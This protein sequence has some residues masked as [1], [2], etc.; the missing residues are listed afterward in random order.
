MAPPLIG[1]TCAWNEDEER[2]YLGRHYVRA[3]ETAGGLPVA[4]P[5]LAREGGVEAL[6]E[7]LNGLLLAGGGD[8]DPLHFG[9]EPL[10]VT[11]EIAPERDRFELALAR[12]A[13]RL[14]LPV[15]GI[16]R[17]LQVLNVAAGGTL[18][19][20]LAQAV[21][22][23]LKHRQQAPGWYAT[24]GLAVAPGSR[25]A[26]ILGPGYRRVN[27]FH[28]QAVARVAPGFRAAAWAPDGVVEAVEA[29][30]PGFALG[31]QFHAEEMAERD[32]GCRAL[33]AAL[34]EAARLFPQGRSDG[35]RGA[36]RKE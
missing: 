16:C 2:F 10:P 15:L 32:P 4:L 24:H 29:T 9:E 33:F 14:G 23:P 34:V 11:G 35:T 6:L 5:A 31:V 19:Q 17:G 3:V 12:G 7:V 36:C 18:Y 30:G 25:L 20:D 27:S 8:L 13:L 28:H 22:R 1:I 21:P 26:G